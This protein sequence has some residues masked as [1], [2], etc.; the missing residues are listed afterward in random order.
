[1][2]DNAAAGPSRPRPRGAHPS[3]RPDSTKLRPPAPPPPRVKEATLPIKVLQGQGARRTDTQRPGFGRDTIFVTRKTSLGSLLG[4]AKGLVLDEGYTH[5]TLYALGAAIPHALLLLHALLDVLPYPTGPNGVW[6]EME[7]GSVVCTDE[8]KGAV[9]D[10]ELAGLG[11]VEED[12]P[13]YRERTKSSLRIEVHV[14][15]KHA[16]VVVPAHPQR[17][18]VTPRGTTEA[19]IP[20]RGNRKRRER[21]KAAVRAARREAA[22]AADEEDAMNG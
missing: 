20:N 5:I 4:R 13:E 6:Y 10:D 9:E 1:M 3:H 12:M 19:P 2:N 7:T 16:P 21:A 22:A 18:K 17:K 14:S 8:M 11:A 15:P